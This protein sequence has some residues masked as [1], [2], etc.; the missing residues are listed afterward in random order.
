MKKVLSVALVAMGLISSSA[1]ASDGQIN[2]TGQVTAVTCS[3]N[4]G[5]YDKN[6]TL[7]SVSVTSMQS[8]GA[9]AGDTAFTIPL[10]G[11]SPSTVNAALM[12]FEVGSTIDT[13]TGSL[14]NQT[15]GGS[16]VQVQLL[17]GNT[18][19]PLTLNGGIG[20]QGL[21]PVAVDMGSANINLIAR[22]RAALDLPT[23]GAVSTYV[24][25]SMA[26]N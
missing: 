26:Y 18:Y 17:D 25:F 10:S 15:A 19:N 16:N 14:K 5:M 13:N 11:C 21:T 9:T 1:F 12:H 4:N 6:V 22:Y 23:A 8:I 7:P 24:T 2:I 20:A 3:I